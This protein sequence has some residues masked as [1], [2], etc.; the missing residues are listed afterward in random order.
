MGF[1]DYIKSAWEWVKSAIQKAWERFKAFLVKVADYTKTVI[2]TLRELAQKAMRGIS[3]LIE[4]IKSGA[5]K[6]FLIF[7]KKNKSGGFT[8]IIKKAQ[9]DGKV[10]Q[11]DVN[12]SDIFDTTPADVDIHI[13]QTDADFNTENVHSVSAEELSEDMRQKV[14]SADVHELKF[15]F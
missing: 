15:N 8:E 1:L 14:A 12:A 4:K 2:R 10:G 13:V 9:E 6:F 5:K 11:A 3:N 7:T